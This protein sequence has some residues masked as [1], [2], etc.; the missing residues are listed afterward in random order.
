MRRCGITCTE[1]N[2]SSRPSMRLASGNR[3]P[4]A[5]VECTARGD[6]TDAVVAW[7]CFRS[8]IAASTG[9]RAHQ[10]RASSAWLCV[11][12]LKGNPQGEEGIWWLSMLPRP[13]A[14]GLRLGRALH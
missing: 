14:W 1:P 5:A 12:P 13:A 6:S 11:T 3:P 10:V 2:Q 9:P 4:D 7:E 8:M